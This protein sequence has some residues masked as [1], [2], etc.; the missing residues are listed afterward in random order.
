MKKGLII[1]KNLCMYIIGVIIFAV[2]LHLPTKEP[3][4]ECFS[5][6]VGI[7]WAVFFWTK[8]ILE[9]INIKEDGK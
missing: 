2:I 5:I 1:T 6:I 7:L 9:L 8:A 4:P 3:L